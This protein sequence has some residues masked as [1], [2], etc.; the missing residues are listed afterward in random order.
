MSMDLRWLALVLLPACAGRV[1]ADIVAAP[2]IAPRDDIKQ[3]EELNRKFKNM[4]ELKIPFNEKSRVLH[5]RVAPNGMVLYL[6]GD[7]PQW[8][9]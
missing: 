3:I 8:W 5:I 1:G 2:P 7:N 9:E 4:V 6:T